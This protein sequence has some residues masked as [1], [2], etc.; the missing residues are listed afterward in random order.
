LPVVD[1][2][3]EIGPLEMRVLGLLDGAGSLAVHDLQAALRKAGQDLAYTTVMTVLVRL[4][5]KG[6]VVRTKEGRRYLYATARRAPSVT[7]GIVARLQKTLFQNDRVR[8]ILTLLD[9]ED[10]SEDDLR[11]LR[12]TIDDKLRRRS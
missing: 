4:H 3:R 12:R 9:D 2:E 7:R 5:D 10:L 8:P 11:A 6:L 1:N